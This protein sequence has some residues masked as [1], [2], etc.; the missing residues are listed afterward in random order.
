MAG[1]N[2]T[3]AAGGRQGVKA[4]TLLDWLRQFSLAVQEGFLDGQVGVAELG[5]GF[6][7]TVVAGNWGVSVVG[8]AV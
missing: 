8:T 3:P 2:C 7:L 4:R 1:F 6:Y 5:Q